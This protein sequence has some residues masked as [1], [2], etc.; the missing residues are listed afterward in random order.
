ME[1]WLLFLLFVCGGLYSG[2]WYGEQDCFRDAL[3]R[4]LWSL[5][6]WFGFLI[7]FAGVT[8]ALPWWPM[9]YP[10]DQCVTLVRAR[11]GGCMWPALCFSHVVQ[12]SLFWWRLPPDITWISWRCVLLEVVWDLPAVLLPDVPN[13]REI[14]WLLHVTDL[15]FANCY[16]MSSTCDGCQ[17]WHSWCSLVSFTCSFNYSVSSTL[18]WFQE[19]DIRDV[20][21]P[22]RLWWGWVRTKCS[23]VAARSLIYSWYC[24]F[25]TSTCALD[26]AILMSSGCRVSLFV[27]LAYACWIKI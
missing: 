21:H 7:F 1:P 11:S 6:Q 10:G 15:L 8:N 27:Y 17:T 18:D 13:L 26:Q 19:Q 20:L 4:T 14:L 24:D 2:L 23:R 22:E 16:Q 3:L 25:G 9:R 12:L 5:L